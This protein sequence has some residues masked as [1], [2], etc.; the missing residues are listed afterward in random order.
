MARKKNDIA[1]WQE[2]DARH[3]GLA[4]PQSKLTAVET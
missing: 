2:G 1:E 3:P 4:D